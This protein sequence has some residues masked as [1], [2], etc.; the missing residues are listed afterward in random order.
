MTNVIRISLNLST[1][2]TLE[3]NNNLPFQH[4]CVFLLIQQIFLLRGVTLGQSGRSTSE[5]IE[6]L[7]FGK[8]VSYGLRGTPGRS[9]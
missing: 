1:R 6:L 2:K 8:V 3:T 4:V 9:T 7:V 5:R